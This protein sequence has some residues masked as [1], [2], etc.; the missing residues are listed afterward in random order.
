MQNEAEK[1]IELLP[2][3]EVGTCVL[4]KKARLFRG[5]P[6]SLERALSENTVQFHHGRIRGAFPKVIESSSD[7]G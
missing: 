5:G 6:K 7:P 2:A 3:E 4:G 1:I